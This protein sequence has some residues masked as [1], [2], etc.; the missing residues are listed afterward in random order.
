[1][2]KS[3]FQWEE[4]G[5]KTDDDLLD[6]LYHLVVSI[7]NRVSHIAVRLAGMPEPD[8]V[9]L[10]S[11]LNEQGTESALHAT[12][13]LPDP[14]LLRRVIKQRAYRA[15]YFPDGLFADP[16]WDMLL[17]L[18]A[19]QAE[20]R[21]VSITSLC[22]ASGVPGTTALR[23]VE[24]LISTGLCARRPDTT[25]RRRTWITLTDRGVKAVAAYF[26]RIMPDDRSVVETT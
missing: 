14:R 1:M 10:P 12:K 21:Q 7:E 25:D 23:Y 26:H 6:K 13:T 24:L 5:V 20:F 18:A 19:A 8:S 16:A 9:I 15:T 3:L 4:L 17:D 22:L 2:T 11:D